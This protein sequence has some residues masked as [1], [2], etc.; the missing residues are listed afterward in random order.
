MSKERGD[1]TTP[2]DAA[3][4]TEDL[5]DEEYIRLNATECP[6][7]LGC[8]FPVVMAT[9]ITSLTMTATIMTAT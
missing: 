2:E 3:P 8:R 7:S 1:L 6:V 5:C 9:K 4:P